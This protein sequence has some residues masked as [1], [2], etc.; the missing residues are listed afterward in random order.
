MI[1]AH[2]LCLAILIFMPALTF[3]QGQSNAAPQTIEEINKSEAKAKVSKS[4]GALADL[5]MQGANK[6]YNDCLK[7]F[8]NHEFC[9]CIKLNTPSGIN[10][11]EYVA[12]VTLSKEEIE[13]FNKDEKAKTII[14]NAINARELCVSNKTKN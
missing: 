7:A 9:E 8:G 4:I 1:R 11:S 12:I 3:S 5:L 14:K 2:F 10:F 13:K 6:K